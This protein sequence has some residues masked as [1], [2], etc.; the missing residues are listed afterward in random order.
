SLEQMYHEPRLIQA[1]DNWRQQYQAIAKPYVVLENSIVG[2]LTTD[3]QRVYTVDDLPVP[4]YVAGMYNQWGGQMPQ[5]PRGQDVNDAMHFSVLQAFDLGSGKM[6]WNVGGRGDKR[7]PNDPKGDLHDSYFL[8]APLTIGGKLYVLTDKNQELRLECL[9]GAKGT[10]KWGQTLATTKEKMLQDMGRRAHAAPLAYG[11]G[12]LVCPTNAGAVFG[13]DFLTH[14]LLWA[15]A[16]RDRAAVK[17]PNEMMQ[18]G[19]MMGRGGRVWMA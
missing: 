14:R 16:Y 12:I 1:I 9:D 4:P 5:F 3:G 11:E 19:M 15:Y 17:D 18:Q 10:V 2:S 6:L 8:G 13:V 7:H